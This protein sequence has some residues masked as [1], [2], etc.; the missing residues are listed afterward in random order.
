[1][2]NTQQM[3]VTDTITTTRRGTTM[4][5]WAD[6]QLGLARTRMQEL[7]AEAAAA[8]FAARSARGS[9]SPGLRDS[10]GRALIR[11]GHALAPDPAVGHHPHQ[12][13]AARQP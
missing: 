7:E 10:V 1:M 4:R 5:T 6:V 8:R 12:R 13:V 3:S 9:T 2:T 11:A